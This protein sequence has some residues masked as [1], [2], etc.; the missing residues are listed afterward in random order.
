MKKLSQLNEGLFAA[1][2][3]NGQI[4]KTQGA[5]DSYFKEHSD[6][7]KDIESIKRDL[8]K[9]ASEEYKKYVTHED[10]IDFQNQYFSEK[11]FPCIDFD[12]QQPHDDKRS[13]YL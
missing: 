2:K 1:L 7:Y 8:K 9:I 4:A 5:I 12:Y 6:E 13:D 3:I 10:A 11:S